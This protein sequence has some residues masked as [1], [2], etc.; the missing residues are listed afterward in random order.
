MLAP[1]YLDGAPIAPELVTADLGFLED[2]ALHVIGRADDVIVTGGAKVHP[3]EVEAVLAATPGVRAACVFAV[4][5][6]RWGQIVAAAIAAAPGF[7]LAAA[8]ARWHAAL[9]PPARP[10]RLAI[11]AQPRSRRRA[12]PIA[13]PRRACTHE[14][15]R[16]AHAPA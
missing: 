5:D 7:D 1:C 10:R 6:E 4:P 15:V 13:A 14:P 11:A 3:L 8:A 12:S 9:P 2:G 16:Y